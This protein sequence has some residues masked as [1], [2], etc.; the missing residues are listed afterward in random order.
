MQKAHYKKTYNKLVRDRIPEII[1]QDGFTSR[2]EI[3]D[4]LAF[5]QALKEKIL[6]EAQEVTQAEPGELIKE[7]ADLYEVLDAFMQQQRITLDEVRACQVARRQER[8]GFTQ[9]IR[10]L[11]IL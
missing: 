2:T 1:R 5:Q 9:R 7:L 3:L 11:E 8:G 4:E 6:E 10:L